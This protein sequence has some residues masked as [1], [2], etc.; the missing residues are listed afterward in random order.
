MSAEPYPGFLPGSRCLAVCGT[1]SFQIGW[2]NC[3][4]VPEEENPLRLAAGLQ[5][6]VITYLS[7]QL[8]LMKSAGS[9]GPGELLRASA[10]LF[11]GRVTLLSLLDNRTYSAD[12][13][14][15]LNW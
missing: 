5:K 13:E 2:N 12:E 9:A 15:P 8:D 3:I 10:G 7:W 14:A 11:S 6:I 4:L 1:G